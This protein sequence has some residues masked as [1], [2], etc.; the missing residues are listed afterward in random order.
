MHCGGRAPGWGI[1]LKVDEPQSVGADRAVNAISAQ[2]VEPRQ[3]AVIGFG[4]ATT[5]DHIGS[6]LL[7]GIIAPG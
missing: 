3:T 7:N 6:A 5:L 4:T 2:A 1:A